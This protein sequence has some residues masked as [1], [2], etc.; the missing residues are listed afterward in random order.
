M[1]HLFWHD[2]VHVRKAIQSCS[3]S[4]WEVME[5]ETDSQL[6]SLST[7]LNGPRVG[8]VLLLP[9]VLSQAMTTIRLLWKGLNEK[10]KGYVSKSAKDKTMLRNYPQGWRT[11]PPAYEAESMRDRRCA[12]LWAKRKRKPQY[13]WMEH[14]MSWV[15]TEVHNP[16]E[17][18]FGGPGQASKQTASRRR[19][20]QE[21]QKKP[22]DDMQRSGWWSNGREALR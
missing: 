19:D 18:R 7:W 15:G 3:E 22:A 11:S 8:A 16:E 21:L 2:E 10:G 9:H 6:C 13:C 14:E 17:G 1:E 20:Q 5:Y 4:C 12:E